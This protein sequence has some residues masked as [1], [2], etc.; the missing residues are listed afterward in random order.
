MPNVKVEPYGETNEFRPLITGIGTS[1]KNFDRLE[2]IRVNNLKRTGLIEG[3]PTSGENIAIVWLSYNVH[4]NESSGTEAAMKTLYELANP[5]NAKTQQWLENTVV[6]L[7]P[8][9]NPDGRDRYANYFNQYG[10]KIPNPDLNAKEHREPWPGGRTNHYLFDLNRDWAWLTQVESRNRIKLYNQWMPHVH[11]DFHEQ[12]LNSPYYFPPAAQPYHEII[13]DWQSEFQELIGKNHARYFDEKGWIYFTKE[14]FDLFYP[15]YGDTY[16]TFNGAIGMTYEKGGGGL[17]GLAGLMQN[18]DTVM[19]HD[20]LLHHHTT[21]LSTVEVSS[22]NADRLVTEFGEYFEKA[23][24]NPQVTYH[25]YVIKGTNSKTRMKALTQWLD[26]Q[27]IQFGTGSST[28]KLTGLNYKTQRLESLTIQDG[29]ILVSA[30]QPKSNFVNALFEP[31]SNLIDSLTYD[32]TAWAVPYIYGLDAYALTET[33]SVQPRSGLDQADTR[34]ANQTAYAYIGKYEAFEDVKWMTWLLNHKVR[35]RTSEKP[36]TIGGQTYPIGTIVVL[37]WDN[38]HVKNFDSIVQQSADKFGKRVYGVSSGLVDSGKDFGSGSYNLVNAPAIAVLGGDQTSSSRFGEIWYF[39]EQDVEYPISVIDTDN[40]SGLDLSNYDVLVVP[41]GRYKLFNESKR[42]EI[43]SWVQKGGR[44][45]IMSGALGSFAD[46]DQFGLKLVEDDDEDEENERIAYED[47]QRERVSSRI[48]GAIFRVK[49]D[50]THPLAFGYDN[51]Y[52]S[53]KLSSARYA[54]LEDGW[55]VGILESETDHLTGFV[56]AKL[57]P[58]LKE[59][60]VFGVE[61]MGRGSVVYMVDNPLFRAFWYN[62]KM[63]FGNAVFI[64]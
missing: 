55:N 48:S 40:F 15:G 54:Y 57:K 59:T 35:I 3:T 32:I 8:C 28:K 18:G 12:S 43:V 9:I 25:T 62:G 5:K 45:V 27:Q 7:D 19:L 22:L 33:I 24:T 17:A 1:Q 29:D 64:R 10:S 46:T 41:G 47:T 26:Q 11:V 36:F 23:R 44:L 31:N 60:L 51:E 30:H 52:Q 61:N 21:G 20:R 4:G 63:I 38:Q 37:R 39:F 2:D 42:K 58:K 34:I 49:M 13:T 14:K 16:P 6:I 50:N 56:G 53:L